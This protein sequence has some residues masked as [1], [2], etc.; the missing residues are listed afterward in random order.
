ME[1][2]NA[3]SYDKLT[4]GGNQFQTLRTQSKKNIYVEMP[5]KCCNETVVIPLSGAVFS[6]LYLKC[7]RWIFLVI[8]LE[9]CVV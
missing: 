4:I 6:S 9:N 5:G 8:S 3:V 1:N 2:L 7:Y